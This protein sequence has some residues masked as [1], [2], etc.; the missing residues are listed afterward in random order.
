MVC[1]IHVYVPLAKCVVSYVPDFIIGLSPVEY[2]VPR[3]V[4]CVFLV[5]PVYI[6]E[7]EYG[8]NSMYWI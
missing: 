6:H 7:N 8:L 2:G 3:L 5:I 1:V 4:S